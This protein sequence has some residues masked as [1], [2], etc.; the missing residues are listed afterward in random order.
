MRPLVALFQNKDMFQFGKTKIFFRAGQV[1]YLERL[2]AD[3][4]KTCSVKIQKVVR[5]WLCRRRWNKIRKMVAAVQTRGRG[6][7]ARRFVSSSSSHFLPSL[8]SS[9]SQSPPSLIPSLLTSSPPHF[10]PSSLPPLL[11]SSPPH[12][13]PSSL[14][15]LLISFL[16]SLPSLLTSFPSSSLTTP[17]QGSSKTAQK[18]SGNSHRLLLEGLS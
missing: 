15:P 9:S 4:L 18:Q 12:F 17:P 1:A 11:T 2:R 16:P 5:G 3:K 6:F 7:L 8:T 14:S 10:L 13:L